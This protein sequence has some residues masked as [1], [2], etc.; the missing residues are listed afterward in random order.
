LAR[1]LTEVIGRSH[2]T[3]GEHREAFVSAV[4]EFLLVETL[5]P[6]ESTEAKRRDM[7]S[8]QKTKGIA[9]A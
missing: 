6:E 7:D 8:P 1:D 5:P 4:L 2:C 9:A 3:H